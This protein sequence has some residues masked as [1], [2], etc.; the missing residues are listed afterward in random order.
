MEK[1][2]TFPLGT[3]ARG[4][5]DEAEA[6]GPTAR[7]RTVEVVHG[8]ADVMDARAASGDEFADGRVR[9]IG[10]EELDEGLAGFEP[11]DLRT[12]RV[13]EVDLVQAEQ[14]AVERKDV[15]ERAH[16]DP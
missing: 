5:V 9:G 16:G 3:D 6:G 4:L 2:D 10:F 8:E 7:E 1:R 11:G 15:V 14:V 12:V 13:V